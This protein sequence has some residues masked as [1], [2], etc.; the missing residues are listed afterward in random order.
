MKKL[1]VRFDTE[2]VNAEL[3]D[4]IEWTH[5]NKSEVARAAMN[6]GLNKLDHCSA[7]RAVELIEE[8]K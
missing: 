8:F 2:K 5:H 3:D 6:I 1:D 4:L 7:S